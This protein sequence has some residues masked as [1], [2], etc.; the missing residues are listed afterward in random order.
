MA[1]HAAPDFELLCKLKLLDVIPVEKYRSSRTGLVICI[2]NVEGPLVNG[3]F[4]LGKHGVQRTW[5][6]KVGA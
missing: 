5:V 6:A 1:D 4:C 3:Y 2:A